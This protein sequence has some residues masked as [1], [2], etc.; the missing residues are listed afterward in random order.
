MFLVK[1][2]RTKMII[3]ALIPIVLVLAGLTLIVL[4]SYERVAQEGVK[5]R[6]AELARISANRLSEG[7]HQVCR[8][9]QE[10][11]VAD[12]IQSMKPARL[13]SALDKARPQLAVFD[14]GVAVYDRQG[15]NLSQ[16][17]GMDF[18]IQSKFNEA[19]GTLRPV[20]SDVFK[21]PG[22]GEDVILVG[23]PIVTRDGRF[24][25]LLAGASTIK[26]SLLGGLCAKVL[27]LKAG[28]SGY[29]YLVDG[30]GRVIYHRHSSM[31]GRTLKSILPVMRVTMGETGA[32]ITEDQ[33][34]EPI[35]SGFASV[36]GTG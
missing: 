36:P 17:Q 12:D 13:Q 20:F 18:P 6:D 1:T 16:R 15:A 11:A 21:Y 32:V 4:Y 22:S 35:I 30:S 25:G 7:L 33:A 24:N 27:E 28:R 23:V 10:M 9:L 31:I 8:I 26:L 34:G 2:L 19:Y 5:Q 14:A 3:S 29:A